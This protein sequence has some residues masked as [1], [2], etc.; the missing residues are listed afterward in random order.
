MRHAIVTW[1]AMND[2]E[3]GVATQTQRDG[4]SGCQV[5]VHEHL[6]GRL[7]VLGTLGG[8]AFGS[9]YHVDD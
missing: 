5:S 7:V 1:D 9:K 4:H 3:K 8:D 6:D 2:T